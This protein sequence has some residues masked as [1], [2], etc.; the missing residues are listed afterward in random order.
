MD[1]RTSPHSREGLTSPDLAAVDART[2]APATGIHPLFSSIVEHEFSALYGVLTAFSGA[3]AAS[4]IYYYITCT[5]YGLLSDRDDPSTS[6]S[7][8][9]IVVTFKP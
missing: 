2:I 7:V 5:V 8:R 3:F 4:V 6:W 9:D 1:H